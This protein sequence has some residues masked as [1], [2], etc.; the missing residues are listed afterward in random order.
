LK[1][2]GSIF[3][4]VIFS[5]FYANFSVFAASLPIAEETTSVQTPAVRPT[6]EESKM[7]KLLN[8]ARAERGLTPLQFDARLTELAREKAEDMVANGY[9]AH[10]SPNFGSP[11][12]MMKSAEITYTS[13]GE[14]IAEN[15][16]IAGANNALMLSDS[17][18]ANILNERFNLVGIG[19]VDGPREFKTIVQMFVEK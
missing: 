4:I 2:K 10:I 17:H 1:F 11:F 7:L 9:F 19:I 15:T 5:L 13:A 3:I 16:T 6:E 18:R 14:N 12:D 8:L